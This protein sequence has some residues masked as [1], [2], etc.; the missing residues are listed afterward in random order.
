MPVDQHQICVAQPVRQQES[1]KKL[2]NTKDVQVAKQLL[3][4]VKRIV[5]SFI[6]GT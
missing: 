1:P 6:T 3:Y 5:Q 2:Y 4:L